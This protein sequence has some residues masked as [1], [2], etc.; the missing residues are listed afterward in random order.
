MENKP[1]ISVI[2][3]TFNSY[4][5]F[6]KTIDSIQGMNVD[7]VVINGGTSP[8]TKQYIKLMDL[9]GVT[10]KDKGVADAFNKGLN[11]TK[12]D[13]V[14]FLSSGDVLLDKNYYNEAISIFEKN[15]KI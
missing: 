5:D 7:S 12:G 1:M 8:E 14:T 10:E 13:Y 11:L 15:P 2:T 6:K 9:H 3:I 4:A